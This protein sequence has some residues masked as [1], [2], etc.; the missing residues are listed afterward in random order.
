MLPPESF[1]TLCPP[2]PEKDKAL[3][4]KPPT[5]LNLV[6]EGG[7]VRGIALVGALTAIQDSLVSEERFRE[8]SI[9]YLA[10]TS[11]GAIVVALLA[12]GYT[13]YEIADF[14]GGPIIAGISEPGWVSRVFAR[15]PILREYPALG[16]YLDLGLKAPRLVTKLGLLDGDDFEGFMRELLAAK[17]IRTFADLRMPGCEH[18]ESPTLR[19]RVH[20]IASDITRGR[21]LVLPDDMDPLRYGYDAESLDVAKAVRMS[22]SVPGLF[23]P[24]KLT[25]DNGVESLIMDGGLLSNFPIDLFDR[26]ATDSQD[27]YREK[28]AP[29]AL[30]LGIRILRDRYHPNR[31]PRVA[32]AVAALVDTAIEA[33]DYSDVTKLVDERKWA[34]VIEINT[35]AVPIFKFG[36]D[37]LEKELLFEAG[38]RITSRSIEANQLEVAAVVHGIA[39][40]AEERVVRVVGMEQW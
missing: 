16:Q 5:H 13:P 14:V 23:E 2:L 22:I 6:L 27:A 30:T 15:V 21:M 25:G 24:V 10:G 40:R 28:R 1:G 9:A 4:L 20:M 18:S 19:Y 7:G 3:E 34:R 11:A 12:A 39:A 26:M 35:E 33:H 8:T 17:G 32:H 31:F 37:A 38:R 36:L 29:R